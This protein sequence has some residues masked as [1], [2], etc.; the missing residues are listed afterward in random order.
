MMNVT[1]LEH[2]IVQQ[3]KKLSNFYKENKEHLYRNIDN[4]YSGSLGSFSTDPMGQL[5][6]PWEDHHPL[7]VDDTQVC[8]LK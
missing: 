7:G 4:L 5:N 1:L 6:V 8:V 2:N 3:L